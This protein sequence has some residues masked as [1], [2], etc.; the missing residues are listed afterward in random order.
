MADPE[1]RSTPEKYPTVGAL[2]RL[3]GRVDK[4]ARAPFGYSNPPVEMLS[5]LL[6]IPAL[7][8]TGEN[9]AYGSPLTI[10]AGQARRMTEDTTGAI[11]GALNLLGPAASTAKLAMKGAKAAAPRAGALAQQFAARTQPMPL[12]MNI[13]KPQGNLNLT[14]MARSEILKG[15]EAQTPENFLNQL[16]GKPGMTK[17][18]FDD[19]ARRYQDLQPN[20]S[21]TKAEFEKNIPPSQYSKA[22]LANAAE[23]ADQHLLNEAEEMVMMDNYNVLEGMLDRLNVRASNTNMQMLNEYHNGDLEFEALTPE[24]QES[25]KLAGAHTPEGS[26]VLD[27]LFSEERE[28]A[29]NTT[30][31]M[32]RGQQESNLDAKGYA[33]SGIQRLLQNPEKS[34]EGYFELGVTHP[35]QTASYKHYPDYDPYDGGLIGHVRGTLIPADA[36]DEARQ[37]I[38][39]L[40]FRRIP[41]SDEVM[42]A[43]PNSMIIEEIQSDA[44]KAKTQTGKFIDKQTGILRQSHGTVFKAA[45][46]HALENGV[47]TVYYPTAQ[48]ISHVRSEPSSAYTSVYDQ[49][50]VKE[51][52][53]PLLK[54]PGVSS[55]KIGDA[56]Y[57][58]D[59]TPEAKDFILKGEG[60]TAPGYARGGPVRMAKGGAVNY[61]Q[62]H[63]DELAAQFHKE[64]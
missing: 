63:I 54:I 49:Q 27:D 33:Y 12:Q 9:I 13:V 26:N 43:K 6:E 59:F 32:L 61:N 38:N 36:A 21:M 62:S 45:I 5:N 18:G 10:G 20:T 44:Q 17:E 16:R 57:E 30:F 48:A 34:G 40:R 23:D 55:R 22:D 51:G 41:A 35:E 25:L 15:P 19:L 3:V 24:L 31:D 60:Q 46:Q 8:R 29:I 14:P 42:L 37:L 47:D 11:G 4:F 39:P 1:I 53:K 28:N 50:V 56:Y 7:Y 64:M 2:S 58:I 52:L